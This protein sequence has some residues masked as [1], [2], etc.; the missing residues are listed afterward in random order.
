[1]A[2]TLRGERSGSG[3]LPELR[4]HRIHREASELE[5]QVRRRRL[6]P[7]Q[8][9]CLR[10]HWPETPNLTYY[11]RLTA[12][13]AVLAKRGTGPSY[14]PSNSP[15]V[16]T[17]PDDTRFRLSNPSRLSL[18][19][20]QSDSAFNSIATVRFRAVERFIGSLQDRISVGVLG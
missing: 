9:P 6:Y 8:M 14:F 15:T 7:Y 1:M 12:R 18:S 4:R 2:L 16:R 19:A 5:R 17:A 13:P 10:G 3:K 20:A 11:R